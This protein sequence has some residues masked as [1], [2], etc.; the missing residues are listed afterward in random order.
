VELQ[1]LPLHIQEQAF[2]PE[3]GFITEAMPQTQQEQA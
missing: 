2:L 3:P 1:Y